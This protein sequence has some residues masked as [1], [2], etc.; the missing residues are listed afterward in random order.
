MSRLYPTTSAARIAASLLWTRCSAIETVPLRRALG[1]KYYVLAVEESIEALCRL[2]A[3][4]SRPRFVRL[5]LLC[6][7][8]R[9]FSVWMSGAGG[10]ADGVRDALA[11]RL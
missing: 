3:I 5:R 10:K 9:K 1:A 6:D 4:S 8:E 2:R 11:D 7:R